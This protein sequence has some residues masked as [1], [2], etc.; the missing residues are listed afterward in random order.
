ML[1]YPMYPDFAFRRVVFQNIKDP[2]PENWVY[3]WASFS[4]FVPSGHQMWPAR[5]SPSNSEG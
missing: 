1:P 3:D 4:I 5:E 2:Q